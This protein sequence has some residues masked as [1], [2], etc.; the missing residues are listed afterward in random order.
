[1]ALRLA[2]TPVSR[3]FSTGKGAG[4]K[5]SQVWQVFPSAP[6]SEVTEGNMTLGVV[7]VMQ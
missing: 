6:P 2:V 4:N 1:M 7:K 5:L 3:A